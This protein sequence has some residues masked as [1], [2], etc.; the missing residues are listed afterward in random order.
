V[1]TSTTNGL[2]WSPGSH[3]GGLTVDD[4]R[5]NQKVQGGSYSVV[6]TG[7]TSTSY[8]VTDLTIGTT[9]EFTVES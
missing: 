1:R 6:A 4:Y 7:V 3:D 8:T 9:Y 5:I 2:T